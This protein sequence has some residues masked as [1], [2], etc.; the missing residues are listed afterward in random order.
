MV[1]KKKIITRNYVHNVCQCTCCV[2]VSPIAFVF[3]II[4]GCTMHFL[5]N[6]HL[7]YGCFSYECVIS[8]FLAKGDFPHDQIPSFLCF[9]T[10]PEICLFL[11]MK[12]V[13]E[14]LQVQFCNT[15]ISIFFSNLKLSL[16]LEIAEQMEEIALWI[17]KCCEFNNVAK[18]M[19]DKTLAIFCLNIILRVDRKCSWSKTY[20]YMYIWNI[21]F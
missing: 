5:I 1:S 6:K 20:I 14:D 12:N 15:Y 16:Q 3:C 10:L 19:N 4:L 21:S 9:G 8:F 7:K 11:F 18:K 13:P 2:I 17:C